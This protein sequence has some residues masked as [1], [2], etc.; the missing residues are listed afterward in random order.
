VYEDA[1]AS[2]FKAGPLGSEIELA[3]VSSSQTITNKNLKSDTNL[4]TSASADSFTR[5]TGNQAII[6][7]PDSVSPDEFVLEDFSQSLTNKDLKSDTNLLTGA[8]SDSFKRETGNQETVTIPDTAIVDN[9]V[10][11]QFTQTLQNKT[12]DATAATGNNTITMDAVDNTYDNSTSGLVATNVQTALDEIDA[13]LDNNQVEDNQ[14]RN[15]KL[16]EGGTWSLGV[17]ASATIAENLNGGTTYGVNNNLSFTGQKFTTTS[18][19]NLDSS[20]FRLRTTGSP[21]GNLVANLYADDG[22]SP[23]LPT[24]SPIATS[25]NIDITTIGGTFSD[26]T[27]NFTS[28][29]S[30]SASTIYHIAI[31]TTNIT[32]SGGNLVFSAEFPG[33]Y[34]GGFVIQ[35]TDGGTSWSDPSA[36][37]NDLYFSFSGSTTSG[38]LT[39]S[40]D[41]YVEIAGLERIRNTIS[42]QTINLVNSNSVATIEVNRSGTGASVR[43]VTVTDV[44]SLV[45]TDDTVVIARRVT[46][47]V[48][49][50][51]SF[52]L[53]PGESSKLDEV[54]NIATKINY[55]NTT[56]ALIAT[57]V[58]AALDEIDAAVDNKAEIDL[59]NINAAGEEV[60]QDVIG[61]I[62]TDTASIDITY[63][64]VG[65]QISADVLPAGVDHDALSNF[66]ANEHVDHT[67][68][69]I[70]TAADSGLTGGGDLTSTRNLSVDITNTTA[71]TAIEQSDE[72]LVYDASATALRKAQVSDVLGNSAPS[73]GDLS[74]ASFAL[75]NNQAVAANVT[76]LTFANATSR[77]AK[78]H[79]SIE[80]DATSDLYEVG[81]IQAIQRGSDWVISREFNGDDANVVIDVNPS[82]QFTYTTPNYAGF[83]SAEI[84]FRAITTT[85]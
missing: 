57:N 60:I 43:P 33:S 68:V 85:V 38:S 31:D 45:V 2:K 18:A 63:D 26:I 34:A 46:D 77:S 29:P 81:E 82:G 72:L 19:I 80:V 75:T 42:A 66:V 8:S 23:G 64:D 79:Y 71:E 41:A 76:G 39:L 27:F 48:L 47:G 62:L 61:G 59:S 84:K 28:S 69:E 1:L 21:T 7:I 78:I 55:D 40:A 53:E 83:V 32:F 56:S 36:G 17:G 11:E 20:L 37:N 14:D 25:D 15:M 24:G 35:T 22:G 16:I 51:R 44:D 6:T 5:E 73:D 50:G 12:I 49:I 3:N 70:A 58:Q 4:I 65:N 13:T 52:L 74:E 10:L 30:L 54:H 67:T 9:I